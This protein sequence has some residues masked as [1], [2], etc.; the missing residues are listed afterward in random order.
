GAR[1]PR[2]PTAAASWA[3]W[4]PGTGL[5]SSS[6]PTSRVWWPRAR[7]DGRPGSERVVQPALD[8]GVDAARQRAEALDRLPVLRARRD[9]GGGQRGVQVQPP[10]VAR[11]EDDVEA[12][13]RVRRG[14]LLV[15][16]AG[17]GV[18]EDMVRD[19]L[20]SGCR[21]D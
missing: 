19:E 2:G 20:E 13:G 5:N 8:G 11:V 6:W 1:S 3:S 10:P 4:T 17:E 14:Q 21:P 12:D 16:P 15:V 7:S 18:D 9:A